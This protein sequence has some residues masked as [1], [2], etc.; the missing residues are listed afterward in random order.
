M[1]PVSISDF[2][3]ASDF[4][5][6]LLASSLN[7]QKGDLNALKV[8]IGQWYLPSYKVFL[9]GTALAAS[10]SQ[11]PWLQ[12]FQESAGYTFP[13]S[14]A[15]FHGE[16]REMTNILL[17]HLETQAC[18]YMSIFVEKMLRV[19]WED[20]SV[21]SETVDADMARVAK[22]ITEAYVNVKLE[23][24][25]QTRLEGRQGTYRDIGSAFW[26]IMQLWTQGGT[27]YD[28]LCRRVQ[29][30]CQL[31]GYTQQEWNPFININ[32]LRASTIPGRSIAREDMLVGDINAL[33]KKISELETKLNQQ[34]RIITAITYRHVLEYL[35]GP[36][37][38][39]KNSADW[40]KFFNA[41]Y[42]K[43]KTLGASGTHPLSAVIKQMQAMPKT[44]V[45]KDI[46]DSGENMY[47]TLSGE[48]HHFSGDYNCGMF[49]LVPGQWGPIPSAI[50]NALRPEK[51]NVNPR[52]EIDWNAEKA[53]Y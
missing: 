38:P 14:L 53:R 13:Q 39:G 47:K 26:A 21:S 6:W 11:N 46:Q 30:F 24:D 29:K 23:E 48:I 10:F 51:V 41:A 9:D 35:S 36:S 37:L 25:R 49:D 3:R 1:P 27:Q 2:L 15:V 12:E 52:G 44:F 17:D 43:A 50:L 22:P 20:T 7:E 4:E 18:T 45:D 40:K 16:P 8:K 19:R 32:A 31:A 5:K 28:D 42:A 33:K 34:D